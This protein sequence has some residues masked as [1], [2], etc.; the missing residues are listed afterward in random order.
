MTDPRPSFNLVD[1]PWV[2]VHWLDGTVGEVSLLE[3]F[4]SAHRIRAVVGEV[5]T[6]TFA[7][8]RLLLAILHRAG[9]GPTDTRHWS[10]LWST[11]E[12][13]ADDID[14]YLRTVQD[15]FDLLSPDRP[16]Y[17]VAGL[18]TAKN[19]V[20]GLERL[21]ADVPNNEPYFTTRSRHEVDRISF[22]EAAR[23]VV[24]CQAFDP[25]GIKSGAVGDPRVKNGRGYPIGTSWAGG[26][27]GLFI[28]GADLRETLLL[29]LIAEDFKDLK[30]DVDLDLP[31]WER[32]R[33]E[34]AQESD[35]LDKRPYGPLDLY[36][37]QSRR[38]RLF[39]DGDGVT[40][41]LIAN[42]DPLGPHNLHQKEPLTAW[43]RS[44]TQEK[45]LKSS[46]VYLP[47]T[48]NPDRSLWRG[49][50]AL[51][52]STS[53]QA[54]GRDAAPSHPPLV[55]KWL[56]HLR[57]R[58]VLPEDYYV[59]TRAIGMAYGA[60][61]ATTT[62]IVD[63]AL[64]FAVA[65]LREHDVELGVT[66]VGAVED[67]EKGVRALGNLAVNLADAAGNREGSEGPRS[68]AQELAYAALDQPFRAWLA[69]LG[70][71]SRPLRAR[72]QWHA[73]ARRLLRRLGEELLSQA[74]DAAW[75]GRELNGAQ[76]DSGRA[77]LI[78]R[79]QLDNAF[80]LAASTTESEVP[81]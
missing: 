64:E 53:G 20:F 27:G 37:W 65:L 13:P 8:V 62:E 14:T 25:S 36:T 76:M 49:L 59:R 55:V 17:Q 43:R 75:V 10:E 67:A 48:H 57:D 81:T 56:D 21:I 50:A 6:Q 45:K 38:I 24:H 68:R 70:P 39:F 46:P 63:D 41:V 22:A 29:N 33:P 19:E 7:I 52:P 34:T 60:Q 15:R 66:A 16:F 12:L 77:D 80:P 26:L 42:G 28:E 30:F 73:Q 61:Q 51:L 72:A 40:G 47:N 2:Q 23:W 31:A 35:D 5:P 32:E 74:G 11:P 69:G 54:T 71:D 58:D 9:G 18:R 4:R 3:L 78:F 1:R 79:Y 44:P